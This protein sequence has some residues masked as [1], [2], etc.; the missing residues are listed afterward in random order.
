MSTFAYKNGQIIPNIYHYERTG[1][2]ADKKISIEFVDSEIKIN[3]GAPI[4]WDGQFDNQLYR[5]DT[6]LKLAAGQKTFSYDLINSRGELRHYD[7]RV[8]GT[9]T[10]DLPYGE[11]QGVK[12]KLDRKNSSRETLAWFA[13]ELNYQLVKLQQFKDGDE[14]GEI[15]LKSFQ[16]LD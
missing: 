2:G 1:T 10:V 6:Q 9:E 11:I 12:V 8:L 7:L 4:I 13:P 5:L 16:L 14:Q 15:R 3:N